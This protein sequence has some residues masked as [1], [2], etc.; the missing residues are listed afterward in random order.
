VRENMMIAI[1]MVYD[2]CLSVVTTNKRNKQKN[3]CVYLSD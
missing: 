3:N 1:M 2:I